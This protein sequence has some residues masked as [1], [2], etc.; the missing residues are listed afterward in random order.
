MKGALLHAEERSKL[1]LIPLL[2]SGCQSVD[3]LGFARHWLAGYTVLAPA[4][5]FRQVLQCYML[6]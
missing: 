6:F 1:A 2:W 5:R 4:P 3:Q